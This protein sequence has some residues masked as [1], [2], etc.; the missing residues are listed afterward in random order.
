MSR[1]VT[2][3]WLAAAQDKT[4]RPLIF[5]E[6]VFDAGTVRLWTGIGSIAWNS[7]TWTGAGNLLE[8]TNITETADLRAQGFTA[9]L[10]GIS[11]TNLA[12]ALDQVVLGR[13]GSIWF[14]LLDGAGAVIADPYLAFKGRMDAPE[15]VDSGEACTIEINYEN[16]L[17]AFEQSMVRY[18][19]HEDMRIDHPNEEACKFVATQ[20]DE[21]VSW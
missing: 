7:Q 9:K 18:Y 6:G 19:T 8:I 16:H 3:A 13:D 20:Q 21:Q 4:C 14:G 10:S 1:A 15:I 5:Y 12:L 2:L 17:K 11:L